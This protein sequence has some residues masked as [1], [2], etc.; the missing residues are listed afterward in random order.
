MPYVIQNGDANLTTAINTFNQTFSGLIQFVASTG[1]TNYVNIDISGGNSGEGYSSVGMLGNEQY[2]NCG[3]GCTVATLLHEMGHTVGLEHEHQRPDRNNFIT[4]NL[5]NADL[6]NVP[7]NFT[8]P[9]W[10]YGGTL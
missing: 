10:N 1:Q 5:A 2:L 4:L 7:G 6:P 3:G 8:L 9:T